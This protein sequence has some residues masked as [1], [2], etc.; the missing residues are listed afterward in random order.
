MFFMRHHRV[1]LE[2]Q[3][4]EKQMGRPLKKKLFGA[5]SN[6][7]IKVQFYNGTES[8]P[9]YIVEQLGNSKFRCKDVNGVTAVCRLV[10][11][12]STALTTGEMTITLKDDRGNVRHALKIAENLATVSTTTN[13][14][15]G[16]TTTGYAQVKWSFATSTSDTYWQIE[17]AGTSTTA[18]STS[19]QA[20]DLEGDDPS[21]LGLFD[22]PVPGSGTF[23]AT[24]SGANL[25]SVGTPYAGTGGVTSIT[26][27]VKGL[28]R[29]KFKGNFGASPGSGIDV[30][31]VNTA[32]GYFGKP[33]TYV[34]FGDQNI[35]T[36]NYYTFEWKGYFKAP[37]TGRYNFYVKT[38]DDT[39]MWIGT[40][41]N[42]ISASNY[43]LYASNSTGAKNTN[44]IDLVANKY[45]P[46]TIQ[47]G[48]Y[49]GAE[50]MQIFWATTASSAA[51][52]GD[53]GTGVTQVWYHNGTTKGY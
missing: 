39:Y 24:L 53:D 35:G 41:T 23:A 36:E 30:N 32:T 28:W 12:A 1:D 6:N 42:A 27:P 5:N 15:T 49:G 3:R 33:D 16:K 44:S 14:I 17:E 43:H 31:F 25:T 52:A 18:M 40:T 26:N 21:T 50:K 48:E 13:A 51:Y 34:S 2:R 7:N 46:V 47:Y 11:K 9:G 8:V 20:V 22:L 4:K 37:T 19:T 10:D 45:Y 38:D 29:R